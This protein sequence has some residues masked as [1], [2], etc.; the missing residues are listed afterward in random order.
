MSEKPAICVSDFSF[1]YRPE[2]PVLTGLSFEVQP[3]EK[4]ALLGG[5]GSGKSTLLLTLVGLLKGQGRLEVNG[6]TVKR[7]NLAAIRREVGFCFQ[8]PQVQLFC[9]TVLQDV[10]FGPLNLHGKADLA[11][12]EAQRALDAVG[13]TGDLDAACH[14]LSL[15]EMRKVALAGVL[16]CQPRVLLLDEPDSYLDAPGRAALIEIIRELG[17]VTILAA[18]HDKVFA[19][20]FSERTIRI[21]QPAG[22]GST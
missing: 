15:G 8:D 20:S 18:T 17:S 5:N 3:G 12:I 19:E 11:R 4:V 7:R 1:A 21:G 2:K 22:S 10:S 16:A 6:R 9:P 13:Y 14:E